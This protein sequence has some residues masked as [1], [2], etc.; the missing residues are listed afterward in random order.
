MASPGLWRMLLSM[1]VLLGWH[2]LLRCLGRTEV[3]IW[4]TEERDFVN[5]ALL[6]SL[7]RCG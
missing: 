3:Q 6:E 2:G 7:L 4:L 5:A 1:Y